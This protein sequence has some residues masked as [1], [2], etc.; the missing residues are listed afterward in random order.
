MLD[1]LESATSFGGQP[2]L[3]PIPLDG[4]LTQID[5]DGGKRMPVIGIVAAIIALISVALTGYLIYRK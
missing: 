5:S 4:K 3:E 1:E 2:L